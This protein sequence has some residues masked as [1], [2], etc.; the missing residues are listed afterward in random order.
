MQGPLKILTKLGL[1]LVRYFYVLLSILLHFRKQ[2]LSEQKTDRRYQ[3]SGG[4][5]IEW[6]S[7]LLSS[8]FG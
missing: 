5:S 2:D 8:S 3:F 4:S 7:L 1:L 6:R